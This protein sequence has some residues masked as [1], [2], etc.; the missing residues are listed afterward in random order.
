MRLNNIEAAQRQQEREE[1]E[2]RDWDRERREAQAEERERNRPQQRENARARGSARGLNTNLP[3]RGDAAQGIGETIFQNANNEGFFADAG[4]GLL[5]FV[6]GIVKR[7]NRTLTQQ[8]KEA[9]AP[10]LCTVRNVTH[11]VGSLGSGF[12]ATIASYQAVSF[13]MK[14]FQFFLSNFPFLKRQSYLWR[15]RMVEQGFFADW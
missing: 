1:R 6:T 15:G 13:L 9:L 5:K 11:A 3:Q 14:L 7:L 12:F 10:E 4:R 2:R 8:A